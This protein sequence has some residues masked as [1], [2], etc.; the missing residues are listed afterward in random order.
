[1]FTIQQQHQKLLSDIRNL[2]NAIYSSEQTVIHYDSQ[3]ETLNKQLEWLRSEYAIVQDESKCDKCGSKLSEDKLKVRLDWILSTANLVKSNI[4]QAIYNK[5]KLVSDIDN[6]TKQLNKLKSD[7]ELFVLPET[8]DKNN[9]EILNIDEENKQILTIEQH[10][11][12]DVED[13]D[14]KKEKQN[15]P[16]KQF[17][18]GTI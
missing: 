18:T 9:I 12:I 3:I 6:K 8:I 7:L 15:P 5:D 13:K 16:N 1:M 10:E 4:E 2:D 17:K 11:I 14:I